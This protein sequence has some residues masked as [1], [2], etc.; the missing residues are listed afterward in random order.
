[1]NTDDEQ[2]ESSEAADASAP[3][4]IAFVP[5]AKSASRWNILGFFGILVLVAVF[6][7][8]H[9]RHGPKTASAAIPAA[10]ANKTITQFL[11]GRSKSVQQM[12]A[13][14]RNTEKQVR[15]FETYPSVKQ[16]PLGNLKTNPFVYQSDDDSA[17]EAARRQAQQQA[18]MRQAAQALTLQS[19]MYS[20]NR[21]ECMINNSLCAKGDKINGFTIEKINP[22]SVVLGQGM[23]RY[24]LRIQK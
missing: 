7:I 4:D 19:I 6:G 14:L 23:F 22:N 5:P 11:S 20:P 18:A 2:L 21:G 10:Q 15:I 3:S 12:R 13:M 24:E 9:L 17:A 16:V 8:I 1:V